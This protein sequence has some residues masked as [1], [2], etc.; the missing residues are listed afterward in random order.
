MYGARSNVPG[1]LSFTVIAAATTEGGCN[2]TVIVTDIVP[3]PAEFVALK[4]TVEAAAVVGL[5]EINPFVVLM[6]RPAGKPVA[7]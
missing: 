2:A 5:P 4:F 7:A 3:V 6:L 1:V